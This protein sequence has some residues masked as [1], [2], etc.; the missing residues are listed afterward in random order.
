[1]CDALETE[2]SDVGVSWRWRGKKG[3][4]SNGVEIVFY[5]TAPGGAGFVEQASDDWSQVVEA[6]HRICTECNCE[7]ACY[8]CLKGYSNQSHHEKLNRHL[9]A[10]FLNP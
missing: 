8:D 7:D 5:D 10:G 6:A 9:A 2:P 3:E 4:T 1:M